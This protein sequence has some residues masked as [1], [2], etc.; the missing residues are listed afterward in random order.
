M[1]DDR[2]RQA[3]LAQGA[4]PESLTPAEFARRTAEES[5]RWAPVVAASGAKLD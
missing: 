4:E 2:I 1:A 5:E 3:F